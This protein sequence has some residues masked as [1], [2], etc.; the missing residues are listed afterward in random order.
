M[1]KAHETGTHP[2][3]LQ[4]H[5]ESFLSD[6]FARTGKFPRSV[7]FS[8][9]SRIDNMALD[10]LEHLIEARYSRSKTEPLRAANLT[11]EKMR[12]LLRL[13]HTQGHL[14]TGAL[15]HISRD[16]DEAGRMLGGW[17]RHQGQVKA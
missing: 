2:V 9:T 3:V 14:S 4:N 6:L 7:R 17:L 8:L 15:E 16:L 13:S 12:V 1:M 5:W 11:L 10:V